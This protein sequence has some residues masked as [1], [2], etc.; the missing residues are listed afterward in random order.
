MLGLVI[1]HQP[2]SINRIYR[3][4]RGTSSTFVIYLIYILD[5]TPEEESRREMR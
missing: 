4:T 5:Q 3:I 1:S 2:K